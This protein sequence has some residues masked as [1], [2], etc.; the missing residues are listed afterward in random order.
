MNFSTE[1]TI[2]K[3]AIN[4]LDPIHQE[5]MNQQG[6]SAVV[7]EFKGRI[8]LLSKILHNHINMMPDSLVKDDFI[9]ICNDIEEYLTVFQ[10]A[11]QDTKIDVIKLNGIREDFMDDCKIL[12]E[13][14]HIAIK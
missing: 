7:K 3:K 10:R 6:A 11:K 1:T 9:K 2:I 13:H 8:E 12:I 14:T 4:I 5:T